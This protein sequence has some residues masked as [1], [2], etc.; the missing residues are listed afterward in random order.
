M[1]TTYSHKGLM[2]CNTV[3]VCPRQILSASTQDLKKPQFVFRPP[4]LRPDSEELL[5]RLSKDQGLDIKMESSV[6][7]NVF[8]FLG[9]V[10]LSR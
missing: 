5:Q 2:I 9:S 8:K 3:L 10:D 6:M 4:P 1:E 7:I